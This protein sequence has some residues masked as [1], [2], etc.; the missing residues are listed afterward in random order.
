MDLERIKVGHGLVMRM[1]ALLA[2]L[3]ALASSSV[4]NGR[5]FSFDTPTVMAGSR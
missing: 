1:S 2:S 5:Y 3:S 4:W